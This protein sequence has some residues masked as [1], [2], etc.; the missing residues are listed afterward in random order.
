MRASEI[1][2]GPLRPKALL[3][4]RERPR[5]ALIEREAILTSL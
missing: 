4:E 2:L 3:R 1:F 5:E